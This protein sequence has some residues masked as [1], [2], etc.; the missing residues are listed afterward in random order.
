MGLGL[1]S[2]MCLLMVCSSK[3]TPLSTSIRAGV[4]MRKESKLPDRRA[5]GENALGRGGGDPIGGNLV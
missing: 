5:V 3:G 2:V 4:E 1:R